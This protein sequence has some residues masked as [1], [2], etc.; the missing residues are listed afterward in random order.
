M[1]GTPATLADLLAECNA[2]GIQLLLAGDGELTIDAPEDALTPDLLDRLKAY[3]A[4]LLAMLRLASQPAAS[5]PT[6][7]TAVWQAALTK[8]EGDPLFPPDVMEALWTA[9]VRWAGAGTVSAPSKPLEAVCRCGST[10]WRDV[11]IHGGNSTRRDC[12]HCRR[13]IEFAV[14]YGKNT[15]HKG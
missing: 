13:F 8:L 5:D 1:T 9:N 7:A 14:W 4:D 11:P 15:R 12:G 2:H 3:K 6:N 10:T